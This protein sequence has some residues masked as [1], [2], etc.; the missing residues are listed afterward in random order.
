[1]EEKKTVEASEF[2]EPKI[3][4][5]HLTEQ[6]IITSST[7]PEGSLADDSKP[8]GGEIIW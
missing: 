6:D 8:T 7:D 4:V 1:M 3:S 2:E 5:I